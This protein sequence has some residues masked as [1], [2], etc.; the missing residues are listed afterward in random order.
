MFLAYSFGLLVGLILWLPFLGYRIVKRKDYWLSLRQRMGIVSPN[1]PRAR[2]TLWIHAVSVGETLSVVPLMHQIHDQWPHLHLV[3]STTTSTGQT[4]AQDKLAS[5]AQIIHFPFDFAT[6]VRRVLKSITPSLVFIVETE[7]WPNFLREC[8]RRQIP[9]V[10]LNGR[11]SDRSFRGYRLISA[12]I[13]PVLH[14]FHRFLMQDNKSA[15]RLKVLGVLEDR[16]LITGNLKFDVTEP[17]DISAKIAEIDGLVALSQSR[18]IVAGSTARGEEELLVHT[19]RNL[20]GQYPN[21]T[22]RLV[23]APRHPERFDEVEAILARSHLSWVRR[24]KAGDDP[25][26]KK[27]LVILLDTIGELAAV[28]SLAEVAFVGGSLVPVGGH[29]VLEPAL[30]GKPTIVGPYTSNFEVIVKSLLDQEAILQL[31]NAP[32]A[33]QCHQLLATLIDLLDNPVKARR[34]GN[35]AKQI[36]IQNQGATHRTLEAIA[37]LIDMQ[38]NPKG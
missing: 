9:V 7:I 33:K 25:K 5:I 31:S 27:C 10:L 35:R 17:T 12:W 3:F 32:R 8:A 22:L 26:A 2:P 38:C 34:L 18:V 19:F 1:T 14:Q 29:N 13:R 6:C 11:I 21:R 36:L 4:V 28:Y 15:A 20:L 24:T 30:Y 37:P 16:L 23:L